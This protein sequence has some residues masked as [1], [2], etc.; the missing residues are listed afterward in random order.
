MSSPATVTLSKPIEAHGEQV[1]KLEIREPTGRDLRVHGNPF[2]LVMATKDGQD[3]YPVFD[4][5]VCAALL[6]ELA[7]IPPSSV[8]QMSMIDTMNAQYA[9]FGFI[10]A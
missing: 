8:D 4:A 1:S 5:A 9:I 10:K 3:P 7:G 2:R 6:S